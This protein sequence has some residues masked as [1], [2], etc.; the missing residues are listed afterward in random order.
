MARSGPDATAWDLVVDSCSVRAKRGGELTGANPTDRSKPGTKYHVVISTDGLP[1]AVVPSPANVHD[2][3]LL[4]DLLRLAQVVCAAIGRLYAD[5]GYDSA[6]NR[7]LC[8]HD[9][10]QPHIRK[11]GETHGSA[12][13]KVRCVV[14]HGLRM[15]AGEQALGST[16]GQ[17]GA[18]H[19]RAAHRGGHLHRR[20]PAQR[21]LKTGPKP[22]LVVGF[23]RRH[24]PVT[25]D[26]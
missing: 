2:T 20:Q 8:L 19:P 12:L 21:I 25:L 17:A 16:T 9:G 11:I 3:R 6:D 7:G 22:A 14:E 26:S 13:G 18:D 5:A 15:A 10:V 4:P 1:L 24:P 23:R